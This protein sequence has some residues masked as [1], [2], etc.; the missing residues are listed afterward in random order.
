MPWL[1]CSDEWTE[2]N[3]MTQETRHSQSRFK[4][5]FMERYPRKYRGVTAPDS[6]LV[7]WRDLIDKVL[8]NVLRVIFVWSQRYV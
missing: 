5:D 6:H 2:L 8:A 4:Y 3:V 7:S 1:L